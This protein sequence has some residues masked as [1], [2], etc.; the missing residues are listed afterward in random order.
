M[1]RD[2]LP[3]SERP[4]RITGPTAGATTV[5]AVLMLLALTPGPA[6]LACASVEH[7][8][9][10][11]AQRPVPGERSAAIRAAV[12]PTRVAVAPRA[13]AGAGAPAGAGPEAPEPLREALLDLPPPAR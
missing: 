9:A 2:H 3:T 1:G 12:A 6:S 8:V 7:A 5:L 13:S 10:A 4:G 11:L